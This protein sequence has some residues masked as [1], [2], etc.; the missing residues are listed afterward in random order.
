MNKAKI[1]ILLFLIASIVGCAG[2]RRA[3]SPA[4]DEYKTAKKTWEAGEPVEA[5]LLMAEAV[6]IDPKLPDPKEFFRDN[7]DAAIAQ[8]KK[9]LKN[10]QNKAEHLYKEQVYNTYVNLQKVYSALE[11]LPLPFS[12]K[13]GKWEWTTKIEDYTA[14]ID[15]A[16]GEA[17][18][19]FF[20][21]IQT[22]LGQDNVEEAIKALDYA[23]DKF[24][25]P[26]SED[27]QA[28]VAASIETFNS[29]AGAKHDSKDIDTLEAALAA[30]NKVLEF[31]SEN[32]TALEGIRE[33]S[34]TISDLYVERG[35]A[36]EA[37][38][39]IES[40]EAAAADYERALFWNEKN[41]T[42]EAQLAGV[43]VKIAEHY[44]QE[45][46]K[47]EQAEGLSAKDKIVSL[48]EKAQ[49]WVAGYKDTDKRIFNVL[50]SV[51]LEDLSEN[52]GVSRTEIGKLRDRFG[53]VSDSIGTTI[54]FLQTYI[55]LTENINKTNKAMKTTAMV[56][57][58]L[59]AI[60]YIGSILSS[61]GTMIEQTREYVIEK[62]AAKLK[63]IQTS[64][65]D[66][67]KAKLE[68][69]KGVI[70]KII[71]QF[72]EVDGTLDYTDKFVLQIRK[73]VERKGDKAI[74]DTVEENAKKINVEYVKLN[75]AL[76]DTNNN[77]DGVANTMSAMLSMKG[78]LKKVQNGMKSFDPVVNEVSKV[79]NEIEKVLNKKITINYLIDKF[80]FTVMDIL[81]GIDSVIGKVQ[82]MLMNEAKK[83]LN[84]LLNQLGV[85]F[86]EIP[87][88]DELQQQ[89]DD[90]KK[91]YDEVEAKF[92]AVQN[93]VDEYMNM[94]EKIKATL[95]DTMKAAACK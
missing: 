28:A 3:F 73:C 10:H 32:V 50:I 95:S 84:P 39:D 27:Y 64:T 58:P 63:Q 87:G 16:R 9:D 53:A 1:P 90:L 69:F 77:V 47:V 21:Y 20:G 66:P 76:I 14:E 45:G 15:T 2:L 40:L 86:P 26:G 61:S 6:T 23:L 62:P 80:T 83:L 34:Y 59:A 70:D 11:E 94:Q 71:D 81:N 65:V 43:S 72:N 56:L 88:L 31:D 93:K 41:E 89:V 37:G 74:F 24:Q 35:I 29:F 79:T 44:Y 49:A 19:A 4:G 12:H 78:T 51:E 67:M 54:G 52:I 60:P 22:V 85:Q 7:F 48:Y 68:K 55:D 13:K 33:L 25:K 82:D 42:A 36:R 17:W 92:V 46:V 5:L 30:Y 91:Y 18:T 8:I 75:K 57:R 38:K